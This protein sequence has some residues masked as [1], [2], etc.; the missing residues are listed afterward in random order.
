VS[1]LERSDDRIHVATVRWPKVGFDD[2]WA[3]ERS[4]FSAE[5]DTPAQTYTVEVEG[6]GPCD[7]DTWR[8]MQTSGGFVPTA[9]WAYEAVWTGAEMLIWGGTTSGGF[10]NTAAR[11]D[12]ATSQWTPTPGWPYRWG[13]SSVWTGTEMMVWGSY[14]Y[15]PQPPFGGFLQWHGGARYSPTSDS[16]SSFTGANPHFASEHEAVWAGG[17][18]IVWGG[19]TPGSGQELAVWLPV[20]SRYNPATD[21]WSPMTTTGAPTARYLHTAVWTGSKMIVWG[22]RQ[23]TSGSGPQPLVNSGALYDPLANTWSPTTLAGAPSPRAAR[24]VDEPHHAPV[25]HTVLD[26]LHQP[27]MVEGIEE[28]PDVGV[29]HPVHLLQH[30]PGR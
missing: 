25:R 5:I 4:A 16:W 17:Q 23:R 1:I 30:D 11:Y 27:S 21:S 7:D 28:R 26:E 18:M 14:T 13:V 2:W 29:E 12:P 10:T 20:G 15:F 9:R 3:A 24:G 8:S 6:Q 19:S 22:G